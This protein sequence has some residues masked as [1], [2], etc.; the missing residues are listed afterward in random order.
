M[1]F[2]RL[3]DNHAVR[4]KNQGRETRIIIFSARQK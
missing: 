1:T 4:G 3:P 2:R